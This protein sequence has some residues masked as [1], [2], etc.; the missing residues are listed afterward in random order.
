MVGGLAWAAVG[1][2]R[3]RRSIVI[4]VEWVGEG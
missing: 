1:A 4:D 2:G 3:R